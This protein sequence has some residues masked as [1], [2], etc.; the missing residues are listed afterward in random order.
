MTIPDVT[1]FAGNS[2]T[3]P[4]A[5][6]Y[7][8][9][10]T[11]NTNN[12]TFGPYGVPIQVTSL[13]M[14]DETITSN[15]QGLSLTVDGTPCTTPCSPLTWLSGSTHTLAA[16]NQSTVYG[17][18]YTFSSWSDGGAATHNVTASSST[19]TYTAAFTTQYLL[20]TSAVPAAGG[21]I[22][23]TSSWHNAGTVVS[24]SASPSSGYR[25]TGFTG[26]LAG[27]ATPQNL[28]MRRAC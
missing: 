10:A 19:P 11:D 20:T 24:V 13:S 17:T 21:A 14:L 9:G 4:P 25:F 1:N 6:Y 8:M 3:N 28:T 15:P 27:A 23:P 7:Y 16:A 18:A 2:L 26:S 22:S 12:T 5:Y